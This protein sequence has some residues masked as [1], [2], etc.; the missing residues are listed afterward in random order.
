MEIHPIFSGHRKDFSWVGF[1]ETNKLSFTPH[2]KQ[3]V[4]VGERVINA[5]WR[6][7]EA[8]NAEVGGQ[9]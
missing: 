8:K 1:G 9:I 7:N 3:D 5:K 6:E 2:S 4:I